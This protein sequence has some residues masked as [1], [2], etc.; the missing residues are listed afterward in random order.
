MAGTKGKSNHHNQQK[1]ADESEEDESD[2]RAN[3]GQRRKTL[4]VLMVC[5]LPHFSHKLTN[6]IIVCTPCI[7]SAEGVDGKGGVRPPK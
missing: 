6:A 3:N 4:I 7:S 2:S 5:Y 1:M